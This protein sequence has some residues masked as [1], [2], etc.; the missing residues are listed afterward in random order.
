MPSPRPI[1]RR[2]ESKCRVC[3]R[4]MSPG[5]FHA[6]KSRSC[7]NSSACMVCHALARKGR[8]G[9]AVVTLGAALSGCVT[10][11]PAPEIV[12]DQCPAHPPESPCAVPDR[13]AAHPLAYLVE[14][15]RCHIDYIE[16]YREDWEACADE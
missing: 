11:A 12:R 4:I 7:G 14:S 6:D 8:R 16:S 3:G 15:L 1:T 10:T 13:D 9:A 2:T 5:A